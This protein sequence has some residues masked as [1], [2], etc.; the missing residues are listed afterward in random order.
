MG[1]KKKVNI[2]VLIRNILIVI[3]FIAIVVL[4]IF[5]PNSGE[6]LPNVNKSRYRAEKNADKL[7]II[8]E[9]E[10][11]KERF[12]TDVSVIQ[13]AVSMALLNNDV[14]DDATMK[15]RVK[16]INK[17][18]KKN[19]WEMFGIEVPTFWVGTW[20][21]DKSGTVKFRFLNDTSV[22]SWAND[23]DATPHIILN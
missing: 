15:T 18:L 1:S 2:N 14:V 9:E 19:S 5:V 21:V 8:Y 13:N 20:S 10:G 16:E 3:V 7:K 12:L 17:E 4:C 22:P 6:F 11:N 23:E